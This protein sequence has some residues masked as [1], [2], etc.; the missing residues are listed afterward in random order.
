MGH[1]CL[2]EEIDASYQDHKHEPKL[3]YG[4]L[5]RFVAA[6]AVTL[7][8]IDTFIVLAIA[9]SIM[10]LLSFIVRKNEPEAGGG[11]AVG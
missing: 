5:Y 4:L 3:A 11:V 2:P 1:P 10:F 8:Y 6:Q 7:A 9:A